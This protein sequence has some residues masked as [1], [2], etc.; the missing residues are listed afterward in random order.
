GKI[1]KRTQG[2]E[3]ER[4]VP[5]GLDR[6]HVEA[7]T[8]HPEHGL[9]APEDV[10]QHGL[11]RGVPAAVEHEPGLGPE[12]AARV[13][14]KRQVLSPP[15]T[16]AGDGARRLL[17]GPAALHGAGLCLSSWNN[18]KASLARARAWTTRPTA[19]IIAAG[20]SDW[21]MFRPM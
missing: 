16:V 18:S 14:A 21:K 2:I 10:R 9:W 4:R 13:H 15:R 8:L 7:R 5:L 6:V 20:A 11:D 3:I 17:L 12:K 19:W 1:A